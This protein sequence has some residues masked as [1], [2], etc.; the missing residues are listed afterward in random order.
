MNRKSIKINAKHQDAVKKMYFMK[1]SMP[2][3][4]EKKIPEKE[5]FEEDPTSELSCIFLLLLILQ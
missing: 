5:D 2:K 4:M 3:K 1:R